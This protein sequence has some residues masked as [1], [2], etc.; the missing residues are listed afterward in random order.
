MVMGV[1]CTPRSYIVFCFSFA[2]GIMAA[3]VSIATISKMKTSKSDM[4]PTDKGQ[5]M[6]D[7]GGGVATFSKG[8]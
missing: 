2:G 6:F 5:L 8:L 4:G 1:S 7:R 3:L